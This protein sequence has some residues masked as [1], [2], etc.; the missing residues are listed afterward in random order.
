MTRGKAKSKAHEEADTDGAVRLRLVPRAVDVL[1]DEAG[2]P[3]RGAV[4]EAH[5]DDPRRGAAE[6]VAAEAATHA[7]HIRERYEWKKVHAPKAWR[8]KDPG[9]E[10]IGYFGGKTVRN[11]AFG[12]YEVVLVHV[13]L[14]GS[15]MVSG[16][17]LIQLIDASMVNVGWPLR[18]VWLGMHLLD[19]GFNVKQFEIFVADGDPLHED[20]LPKIKGRRQ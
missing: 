17:H 18:I 9:T 6:P 7:E 19:N 20:A 1:V 3:L 14:Q 16:A 2:S 11:G 10:L 15:Y 12:Q 13:P 5:D 8:P 4:P